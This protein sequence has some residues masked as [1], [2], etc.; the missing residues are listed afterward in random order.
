[1]SPTYT[2]IALRQILEQLKKIAT[3]LEV[4]QSP[5]TTFTSYTGYLLA[6]FHNRDIATA[7]RPSFEAMYGNIIVELLK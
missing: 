5:R 6:T 2:E 7:M 4:K 1:M 3:A